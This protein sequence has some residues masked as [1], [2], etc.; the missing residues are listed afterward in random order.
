MDYIKNG[1]AII[2][3][4]AAIWGLY[5][6]FVEFALQGT[7]KRADMFL[8]KQGEY[9]NNTSFNEIRGL[10]E[11]DD[12]QLRQIG[13]EEKRAYLTFFEEIAVLKNSKLIAPDLAYYMFG[14]YAT[15]CLESENFWSNINKQD[16]FWNVFLRFATEMKGRLRDQGEVIT[17]EV[18]F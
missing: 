9:F 15:R 8:K 18:R 10:L 7:Q 6:G 2:G 4:I 14:Y 17:H 3:L 11:F 13:F 16:I 5:K 1:A 12:V